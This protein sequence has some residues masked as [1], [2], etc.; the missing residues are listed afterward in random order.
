[1]TPYYENNGI[2]LYHGDCREIV[3]DLDVESI[4]AVVTDPPYGLAFMGKDWDHGIPGE[5]FWS[6]FLR[7]CKP[8]AHL[9]AFGGT[10]TFH[11]LTCAI[12][13]AGWEIRDC[14]NW[15]YGSGFPK[16]LD[17]SKA[18]DK[19][20]RGVPHGGSDPTSPNH[21]KYKGGC[22]AGNVKGQGFGAGPGQFMAEQGVKDEREL[23]EDAQQWNG[24]GTALK[25][26]WEP[27]IL[28]MK[29]LDGTFADNA[30]KHSVAGLNIDECRIDGQKAGAGSHKCYRLSG[31]NSRPYHGQESNREVFDQSKGR[32]PANVIHDGSIEVLA[33]F[34]DAPGQ[35]G[36]VKGTEPSKPGLNT[37][38]DYSGHRK[39]AS[40]RDGKSSSAARFFYCAKASS[41]ERGHREPK[42]LPLFGETEPGF[43]NTHPTVKPL[44]LMIYLLR[45]VSTPTGGVVLDPFAGSGTTLLAA[46]SLGRTAIGIEVNKEYCEIA[47]E[48]LRQ[49]E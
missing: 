38:G 18:I 1:M 46:A 37:Y 48:R 11:R 16:S 43:T 32:F 34:P 30:L 49:V 33:S 14:L 45:L 3:A 29:P 25:P 23:G 22:S 26:A 19:A 15:L 42:D 20:S 35:Q 2:T 31:T 5:H 36:E 8:G 17:I 24:W 40:P 27:I 6:A 7:A 13:D 9:L 39:P 44:E 28:S 47:A 41:A 21:G 10:R 12:E 4:D